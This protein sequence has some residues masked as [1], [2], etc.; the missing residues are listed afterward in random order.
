MAGTKEGGL[1]AAKTNKK[2]YGEDFYKIIGKKGG[3]LGTG[4]GFAKDPE[5]ASLA[6]RLGGLISTRAEVKHTVDA[7]KVKQVQRDI[8]YHKSLRKYGG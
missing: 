6:G 7:D 5:M 4:G 8:R 3:H 2:K 1:Q